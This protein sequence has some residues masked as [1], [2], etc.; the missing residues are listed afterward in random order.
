[1]GLNLSFCLF[2]LLDPTPEAGDETLDAVEERDLAEY[3]GDLVVV[4]AASDGFD[5]EDEAVFELFC[6]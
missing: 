3:L 5:V 1:M 4:S 6:P 2:A